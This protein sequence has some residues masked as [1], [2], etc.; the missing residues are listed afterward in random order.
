ME[1]QK[2]KSHDVEQNHRTSVQTAAQSSNGFVNVSFGHLCWSNA[3]IIFEYTLGNFP[4]GSIWKIPPHCH[5]NEENN[6][7]FTMFKGAK[8]GTLNGVPHF[9]LPFCSICSAPRPFRPPLRCH[10]VAPS[11]RRCCWGLWCPGYL[12]SADPGFASKPGKGG[13]CEEFG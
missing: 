10:P 2:Q 12:P 5:A 9:H 1:Y 4:F 13:K 6:S 3:A 8:W 11:R 7:F